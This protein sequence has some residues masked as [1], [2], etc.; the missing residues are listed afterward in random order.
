MIVGEYIDNNGVEKNIYSIINDFPRGRSIFLKIHDYCN[1][2]EKEMMWPQEIEF[3]VEDDRVELSRNRDIES[4]SSIAKV[5]I[6]NEFM[7][8][9]WMRKSD[10]PKRV[11]REEIKGLQNDFNDQPEKQIIEKIS[12]CI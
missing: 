2:L 9:E 11:S 5:R 1:L 10:I 8:K 12:K 3:N 6:I 4:M 7:I